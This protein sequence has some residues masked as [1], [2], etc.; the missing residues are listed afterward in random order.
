MKKTPPSKNSYNKILSNIIN[1]IEQSK[2][3]AFSEVNKA[4]LNAYWDIGK[5]LSEN[6]SYGKSVVE[7]LSR[8]LRLKYP[9]AKGYSVTN[10]WNMKRFYE[11]YN[12][13]LQAVPG[14]S[15][16]FQ[17]L[18]AEFKGGKLQALAAELLF[19]VS[20]TNHV[21]ILDKTSSDEEKQ[22]YL[23]MCIKEKWSKRELDRQ[24]DSSLFERYMLVDKPEKVTALI[25][26]N[27]NKDLVKHFKDEYWDSMLFEY[28]LY[29]S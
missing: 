9:E 18:V 7:Q 11:T 8:D 13:K 17:P 4:L 3:R 22:F 26:K 12:Q 25:P 24:L 6:A 27:Q 28:I 15:G 2:L 1:H 20:W 29:E 23:K 10:L 21:L 14:E 5:E 16:K 19:N